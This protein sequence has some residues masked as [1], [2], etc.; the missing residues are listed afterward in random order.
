[1]IFF[2]LLS[3]VFAKSPAVF[4]LA[5]TDKGELYVT[6]NDINQMKIMFLVFAAYA[7]F[8]ILKGIAGFFTKSELKTRE[9]MNDR[10]EKLEENSELILR[11]FDEFSI[12][13]S[14]LSDG[15]V[16]SDE[17]RAITRDEIA[18]ITKLRERK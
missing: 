17:V 13:L 18:Y 4:P 15:Q 1:M 6:F 11:R 16:T 8:N 9:K 12:K 2:L 14:H 10:L 7:L 5:S 3:K